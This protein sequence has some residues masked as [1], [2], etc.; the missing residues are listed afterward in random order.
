MN[1]MHR[2]VLAAS[3]SISTEIKEIV[4]QFLHQITQDRGLGIPYFFELLPSFG[5]N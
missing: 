5:K 2:M 3:N 4:R 1:Q